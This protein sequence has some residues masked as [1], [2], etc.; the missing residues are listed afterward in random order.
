MTLIFILSKR[1]ISLVSQCVLALT[2]NEKSF[3]AHLLHEY[4]GF[5]R[6]LCTKMER[7]FIFTNVGDTLEAALQGTRKSV[8]HSHRSSRAK[9]GNSSQ[10]RNKI[11]L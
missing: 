8:F 11:T 6:C 4:R 5:A 9:K 10:T 3:P 1:E 2:A 7:T